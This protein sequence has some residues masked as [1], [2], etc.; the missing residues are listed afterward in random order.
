MRCTKLCETTFIH[1][2]AC[3]HV[4]FSENYTCKYINETQALHSHGNLFSILEFSMWGKM[5]FLFALSQNQ[6]NR[7][8]QPYG[9]T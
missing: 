6:G 4:D 8:H 9:P 2:S 7:T 5:R 1:M 3:L